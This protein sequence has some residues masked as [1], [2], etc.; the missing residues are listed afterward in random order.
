V[1]Q[2][3]E[4]FAADRHG[5]RECRKCRSNLRPAGSWYAFPPKDAVR[6]PDNES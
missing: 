6:A 1:P 5:W 3:Q 2:M 4:K